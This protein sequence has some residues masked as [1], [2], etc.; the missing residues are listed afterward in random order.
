LPSSPEPSRSMRVADDDSGV[1]I[2]VMS[3]L[4][5]VA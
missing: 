3:Y 5:S 4:L 1:P 2:V